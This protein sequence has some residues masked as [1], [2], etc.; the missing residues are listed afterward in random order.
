MLLPM[1]TL[2][3]GFGHKLGRSFLVG[4]GEQV[5]LYDMK[6]GLGLNFAQW[7]CTKQLAIKYYR[8]IQ[9]F[10]GYYLMG[11]GPSGPT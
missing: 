9:I 10:N 1:H 6:I 8:K 4:N 11:A 2:C 7:I 3:I 5:C